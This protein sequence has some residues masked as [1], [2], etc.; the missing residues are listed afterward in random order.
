[1][2]PLKEAQASVEHMLFYLDALSRVIA[3]D[4]QSELIGYLEPMT[5]EHFSGEAGKWMYVGSK[6]AGPKPKKSTDLEVLHPKA[7]FVKYDDSSSLEFIYFGEMVEDCFE[8]EGLL[9]QRRCIAKG[10]FSRG[11][12]VGEVNATIIN[13]S[14]DYYVGLT[15][16]SKP[17]GT[18]KTYS[19]EE[20]LLSE[21]ELSSTEG[22]SN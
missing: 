22:R 13:E 4:I 19:F 10:L 2:R 14:G 21:G 20:A 9:V 5:E 8:G 15:C 6:T 3:F 11:C 12:L 16:D 18:G 17:I 7:L 1:M